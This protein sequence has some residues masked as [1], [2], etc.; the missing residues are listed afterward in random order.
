MQITVSMEVKE[1]MDFAK[2][3]YGGYSA[4]VEKAVE[5]FLERPVEPYPED[6]TDAETAKSSGQWKSLEAVKAGLRSS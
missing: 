6:I 5:S 2:Y 1:K 4:L 3:F